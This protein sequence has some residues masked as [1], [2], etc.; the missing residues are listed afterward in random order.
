MEKILEYSL[1]TTKNNFDYERFSFEKKRAG[2]FDIIRHRDFFKFFLRKSKEFEKS[3]K[4]FRDKRSQDLYISL[5]LFKILSHRNVKLLTNTKQ[6]WNLREKA[7][8]LISCKSKIKLRH[9]LGEIK[10]YQFKFKNHLIKFDGGHRSIAWSFYFRQYFYHRNG[11]KI[12][13]ISGDYVL[14]LG[15]CMG[16]T[17]IAFAH[18]V[19]KNGHVYAFDFIP[20]HLDLI[21][22]NVNQNYGFRDIVTIM[23]Y[24]VGRKS[25][26]L[27]PL[28]NKFQDK[29][30]PSA[31]LVYGNIK[32]IDDI[33]IIS[34]DDIVEKKK[35]KKID[36]IKMDIEGYEL[37]ALKGAS[38][39]IKKFFPKL[40]ISIYHKDEDFYLI[41]KY[42]KSL[43]DNYSL[44]I[45][46]YTIYNE[47]TV[48]YAKLS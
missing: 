20:A 28:K 25:N 14:D 45:D 44:Y 37:E 4:Y 1:K 36:F 17:T 40:A 18:A 35:I 29:I 34:I 2:S 31:S 7:K 33:P 23:P 5:I 41:P 21:S 6:H 22:Y 38:K 43:N 8:A 48:L 11:V 12:S 26:N 16:D 9:F 27:P 24:A 15:A 30:F 10:H 47:E 42:I 46:H 39:T 13:P 3:F 32:S 19:G